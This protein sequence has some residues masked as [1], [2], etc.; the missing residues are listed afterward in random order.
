MVVVVVLRER[1]GERVV[2]RAPKSRLSVKLLPPLNCLM[3]ERQLTVEAAW[4]SELALSSARGGHMPALMKR[5]WSRD[6]LM[7]AAAPCSPEGG[8]SDGEGATALLPLV[9]SSN[10]V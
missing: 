10:G 2:E 4:L 5:L 6:W 8:N 9:I 1:V 3:E 7:A